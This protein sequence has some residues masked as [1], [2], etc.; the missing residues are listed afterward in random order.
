MNLFKFY[1]KLLEI[2]SLMTQ[3]DKSTFFMIF[4]NP[5]KV[6]HVPHTYF[7]E[8]NLQLQFNR[9]KSLFVNMLHIIFFTAA[10][11]RHKCEELAEAGEWETITKGSLKAHINT[12][13][14]LYNFKVPTL[15]YFS[16]LSL[17]EYEIA[18]QFVGIECYMLQIS[19][20]HGK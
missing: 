11:R 2:T 14:T 12:A 7:Y 4:K 6:H 3:I 16:S 13:Y 8:Q 19:L 10:N 18:S 15:T 5:S 20:M 9:K 1:W 17:L